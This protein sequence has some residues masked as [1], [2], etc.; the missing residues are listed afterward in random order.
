MNSQYIIN[1]IKEKKE[2]LEKK[3]YISEIGLFGSTSRGENTEKSDIDLLISFDEDKKI[4]IFD[5]VNIQ[6]YLKDLLGREV[7]IVHKKMIRKNLRDQILKET[8]FI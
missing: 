8:I 2:F 4:S 1:K 7:D 6:N 5:L 3:Y